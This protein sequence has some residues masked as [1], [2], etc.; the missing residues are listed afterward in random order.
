MR[1]ADVSVFGIEPKKL[2]TMSFTVRVQESSIPDGTEISTDE[3]NDLITALAEIAGFAGVRDEVEDARG[4]RQ[5]KN[6]L[7]M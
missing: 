5:S 7:T 4:T 2:T 1:K 3:F 6:A